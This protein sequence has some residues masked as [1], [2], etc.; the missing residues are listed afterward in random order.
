MNS[1]LFLPCNN[2]LGHIRRLSILANKF[3]FRSKKI[4]FFLDI[5]K[6][7]KFKFNS[8]IKKILFANRD[9]EK[10]IKSLDLRNFTKIISDNE[11]NKEIIFHKKK[12]FVIANFFWEEIFNKKFKNVK[13][14]KKKNIIVFS[15]YLFSNIKAKINIKKIGFFEKFKPNKNN[16]CILIAVGSAKSRLLARFKIKIIKLLKENIFKK[17]KIYLDPKL[18]VPNLKKF[19][20]HKA[21]FSEKMY[22]NVS[23]AIIKPGLGTVEECLKRGI[24]IFPI[25][26]MEN[27]EFQYNTHILTKKKLGFKFAK[28]EQAFNFINLKFNDLKFKNMFNN[29]CKKLK[30]N[31]ELQIKKILEK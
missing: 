27:K 12:N 8:K 21:D 17:K 28:L 20:I 22:S 30:W 23:F 24:V 9:K 15:N 3:D 10:L 14:L 4:F 16:D 5:K 29:R 19:N 25:I 11:I 26:E 13:N 7:N 31:G 18:Y 6:K 1:L 2:G